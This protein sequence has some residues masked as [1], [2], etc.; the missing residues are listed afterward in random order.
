MRRSRVRRCTFEVEIRRPARKELPALDDEFAKDHGERE[1]LGGAAGA[2]SGKISRPQA[3]READE[4][5]GWRSLDSSSSATRSMCRLAGRPALRRDAHGVG[6]V[7][8]RRRAGRCAGAR[9]GCERDVDLARSARCVPICCSMRRRG[10]RCHDRRHM[11]WTSRNRRRI[12]ERQRQAPGARSPADSIA[13]PEARRELRA[14]RA[15][16]ALDLVLVGGATITR[17]R[18]HQT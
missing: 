12:A 14:A 6:S 1:S 4:R 7:C 3:Q 9:S 13:R 11:R 16:E 18:S 17:S 5:C 2:R 10:A 8:I 15:G